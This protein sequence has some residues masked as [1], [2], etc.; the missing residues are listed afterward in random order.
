MLSNFTSGGRVT[1]VTITPVISV[2]IFMLYAMFGIVQLAALIGVV[3]DMLLDGV[4]QYELFLITKPVQLLSI[5][6]CS[7]GK[8]FLQKVRNRDDPGH[9]VSRRLSTALYKPS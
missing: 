3:G 1:D 4:V 8:R 9:G 2:W 5:C 6:C 7:R